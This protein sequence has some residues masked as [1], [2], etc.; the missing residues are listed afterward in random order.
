MLLFS[1]KAKAF[2][3]KLLKRRREKGVTK[4]FIVGN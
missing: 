2:Y 1:K 3:L 4:T